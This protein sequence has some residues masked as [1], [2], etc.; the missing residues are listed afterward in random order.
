MNKNEKFRLISNVKFELRDKNGKLK[1]EREL[2]NTTTNAAKYG[3]IDQI[4]ASPSL[5][6]PGWIELGTGTPGATLLG[7]YISESRTAFDTMTRNLN[8]VTMVV[9]FGAGVGTGSI[10]EA[11]IFDI[12]TQNT[13]NMW[14]YATGFT[15]IPKAAD[16]ILTVTWTFTLS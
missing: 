12:V 5:N 3:L 2:H 9:E 1:L 4:L 8:V 16:D 11:G 6:K 14:A 15:A 7:A 10:T 13:A